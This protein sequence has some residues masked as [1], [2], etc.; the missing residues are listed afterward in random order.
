MSFVSA[1]KKFTNH[2]SLSRTAIQPLLQKPKLQQ[3]DGKIGI[4]HVPDAVVRHILDFLKQPKEDTCFRMTCDYFKDCYPYKGNLFFPQRIDKC[5]RDCIF[6]RTI[7]KYIHAQCVIY[8]I[9]AREIECT[10]KELIQLKGM[11]IKFLAIK[12]SKLTKV[13]M[14]ALATLSLKVL[15]MWNATRDIKNLQCLS[16]MR[17]NELW[18]ITLNISDKELIHL[19]DMPLTHVHLGGRGVR[20]SQQGSEYLKQVPS[21]NVHTWIEYRLRMW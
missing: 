5:T 15:Y 6:D 19:K 18:L 17:L 10:D 9:D 12:V 7:K 2:F 14:Q 3:N 21:E 13:G 20:I 16:R 8:C 11:P 4:T 1:V